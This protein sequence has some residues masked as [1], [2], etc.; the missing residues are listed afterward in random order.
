MGD[1]SK[2]KDEKKKSQ[3]KSL[4]VKGEVNIPADVVSL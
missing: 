4:D 2:G 1:Y 3:G